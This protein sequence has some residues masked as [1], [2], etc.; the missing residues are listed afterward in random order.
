MVSSMIL[1][2]AQIDRCIPV[3]SPLRWLNQVIFLPLYSLSIAALDP[4]PL[5]HQL[6]QFADH[7]IHLDRNNSSKT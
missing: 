2:K 7:Q 1:I 5:F 6:I 4:I 3:H